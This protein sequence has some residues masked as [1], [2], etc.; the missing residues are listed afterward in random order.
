MDSQL[1][2]NGSNTRPNTQPAARPTGR[3]RLAGRVERV[4][5]T[6]LA[7]EKA[8]VLNATAAELL[9]EPGPVVGVIAGA[10][11]RP[12]IGLMAHWSLHEL[13]RRSRLHEEL[14]NSLTA[15]NPA[16][17][18]A[19]ARLCGAAR[20]TEAVLWIADL[21][22]DPDPRVRDA[23][24]RALGQM[25]GRRAVEAL[26]AN[27]D[28]IPLY[29]LA[30][31]LSEAASDVDV[32]ALMRAP[33]DERSAV[34][35]VLACGLRC[36]KLRVSPLLGIAHDRRWPKK[37]RIAA[38]KSLAT[39]GD[40]SAADGLKRLALNDPDGKVKDAADRAHRRLVKRVVAR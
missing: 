32:E 17:R 20:V 16:K 34:A 28:R 33:A 14:I 5:N 3:S 35:T 10:L 11:G 39:I 38:C 15:A 18:A 27:A 22:A 12:G 6:A 31:A 4:V 37:V 2:T 9:A 13:L 1:R 30:I 26:M 19:A 7:G 40:R 36:D 21:L 24:V 25:G 23:A 29:R 8:A